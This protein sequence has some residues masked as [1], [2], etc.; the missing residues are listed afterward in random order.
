MTKEIIHAIKKFLRV[1]VVA[2]TVTSGSINASAQGGGLDISST[3]CNNQLNVSLDESGYALIELRTVWEEGYNDKYF[4]QLDQIIVEIKGSSPAH[5]DMAHNG[6]TVATTSALL[7]CSFVSKNVEYRLFKYFSDGTVDSCMGNVLI[8]DKIKP[9]IVCSDLTVNCTENT[10]PYQLAN[11]YNNSLPSATDNCGT[12]TLTFQD[13]EENYN[14]SNPDFYRKIKRVWRA[15]DGSGNQAT[16]IQNI[17]IEKGDGAVIQFPTYLSSINASVL[18]SLTTY[19]EP[20]NTGYPT[21][22]G[23]NIADQNVSNFSSSYQDQ[24]TSTSGEGFNILRNWT[25]VDWCTNEI[26]THAQ[27]LNVLEETPT[28]ICKENTTI[29]SRE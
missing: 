13:L 9:R 7:D 21:L 17:F 18:D 23:V 15:I 26:F 20:L 6:N 29:F 14:C 10:D 22:Y 5:L 25:V 4:Q 3:S 19:L 1:G 16:C 28:K 12:P 2:V 11:S 27:I 8:E 24:I